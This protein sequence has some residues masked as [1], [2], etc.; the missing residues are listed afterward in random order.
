VL[1]I[2]H[3]YAAAELGQTYGR[4]LELSQALG[5]REQRITSL[6]GAAFFHVVSGQF[7]RGLELS[8]DL[9]AFAEAAKTSRI[10]PA[11]VATGHFMLAIGLNHLGRIAEAR[12]A[13][14]PAW[15]A[16]READSPL[17]LFTGLDMRVFCG[18]YRSHVLWICGEA[19]EAALQSGESVALARREAH[20]FSLALAL[21]YAAMLQVFERYPDLARE[22]AGEAEGI[23]RK[24]AFSYYL[25]WSESVLGWAMAQRG[26]AEEG[27]KRLQRGI[28][29]MKSTGAQLR[30]PFYYSLLAEAYEAAGQT[31]EA[32]ASVATGLAMVDTNGERWAEP[33]LHRVHGQI[34]EQAGHRRESAESFRKAVEAALR[35][36]A[37]PF[38]RRAEAR[39]RPLRDAD[40]F[41]PG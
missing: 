30:L 15:D 29:T 35:I 7:E 21:N 6:A 13:M 9:I 41:Q 3:G 22:C 8:Q 18:A 5:E 17:S 14:E 36:G 24:Y 33:E 39:L 4:A 32:L 2:A 10:G 25:G 16:Y 19:G 37:L 26:A 11:G 40:T 23:C 38:A 20:P 27:C 31:R 28:E 1:M 12:Q 34:L